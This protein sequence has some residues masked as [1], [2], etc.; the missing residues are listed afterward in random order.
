MADKNTRSTD[1]PIQLFGKWG[2]DQ[3]SVQD[4]G[5]QKYIQ[6]KPIFFPHSGGRHEHQRFEKSKVSIVERLINN[7]MRHGRNCGKKAKAINILKMTFEIIHLKSG[8]NPIEVLVQA[9]EE[10]APCEDTTRIGYGGITYH[11]AVDISPQRRVDLALRHLA[12]GARRSAFGNRKTIEECLADELLF[13]AS[14]DSRSFAIQ[15]R[16]EMERVAQ[17]SR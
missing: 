12:E 6:L 11:R 4:Q 1:Q 13:A 17:A 3:I 15:R 10:G 5:L 8:Q 14:G 7:M 2:F 9:V 16:D